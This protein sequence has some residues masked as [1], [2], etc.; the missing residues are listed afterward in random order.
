[1][2]RSFHNASCLLAPLQM[3]NAVHFI[4]DAQAEI[5]VASCVGV[6]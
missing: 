2:A 6:L 1:M 5:D 3:P 4:P